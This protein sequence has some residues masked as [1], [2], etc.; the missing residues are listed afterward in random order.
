MG[1]R[2]IRSGQGFVLLTRT[3]GSSGVFADEAARDTYFATANGIIDLARMDANE[4]II[5]KLLDDGAGEI[6]YQQRASGVFVDVTSLVQGETGPAGAT[7]NSFFFES[8]AARDDF[9]NVVGNEQL[10]M[11]GL[12]V[13]V[14]EGTVSTNFFWSGEDNPSTYDEDLFRPAS[15][16][17]SPGSL[18]LGEGGLSIS[19]G[20]RA[21]NTTNAY[22]ITSIPL[23]TEFTA[24]GNTPPFQYDFGVSSVLSL[25]A[26]FDTALSDPQSMQFVVVDTSMTSGYAIRPA[27]IGDLRVQAFA[28]T[29]ETDPV[30]LDVTFPVTIGEIGT[31]KSIVLDNKT[32]LEADDNIL[33]KFSGI[34]LFGGLQTTGIFNG[35]T[36]PYLDVD[37][38]ILTPRDLVVLGDAQPIVVFEDLSTQSTGATRSADDWHPS[39]SVF[40]QSFD[41]TT[42]DDEP[43]G[44]YIRP[45]GLKMYLVGSENGLV[46]EY[47][48]GTSWDVSTAVFLQS[49]NPSITNI[50]GVFFRPNGLTMFLLDATTDEVSEYVLGT[51]W[52]ISTAA[53]V[54]AVDLATLGGGT[55]PHDM[56][57]KADGRTFYI[58]ELISQEVEQ[59]D[60]S[61]PW[62]ISTA[63]LTT[64]FDVGM[65]EFAVS[66]KLDGTLMFVIDG[67]GVIQEFNLTT[68][69]LVD[70]AELVNTTDLS[71][72]SVRGIFHKPDGAKFYVTEESGDTIRE[73]NVGLAITAP[74]NLRIPLNGDTVGVNFINEA[75][76]VAASIQYQD[77]T[78]TLALSAVEMS[79]TAGD[80]LALVAD[81]M[82]LD[83]TG[84]ISINSDIFIDAIGQT[85]LITSVGGTGTPSF[86]L[87]DA[88][89]NN[90]L[91][92]EYDQQINNVN[93]TG[94]VDT[95]IDTTGG[96]LFLHSATNVS[97]DAR[98]GDTTIEATGDIIL[99]TNVA[100]DTDG[101]VITLTSDGAS[102]T[103]SIEFDDSSNALGASIV[104]DET[105]DDLTIT[106]VLGD[107]QLISTS[108]DIEIL[109]GSGFVGV[110]TSDPFSSLHV[111]DDNSTGGS[112]VGFNIEQAGTGDAVQ[113][114]NL[115]GGEV[116]SIGIDN[117]ADDAFRLFA[118]TFLG[119]GGGAGNWTMLT[120]GEFGINKIPRANHCLDIDTNLNTVVALYDTKDV[121]LEQ[122][123][124]VNGN[125]TDMYFN[126]ADAGFNQSEFHIFNENDNTDTM[127]HF[128]M[129]FTD[130]GDTG[131]L[132]VRFN[133]FVAVGIGSNDEADTLLHLRSEGA[134]TV[135]IET[136]ETTGTNGAIVTTFVGDQDP[137]GI[138]TGSPGDIYRRSNGTSSEIF[139]H[140]GASADNTS[141][142]DIT[143][144][145]NVTTTDSLDNGLLLKAT[146][147]TSIAATEGPGSALIRTTSGNNI[148]QIVPEESGTGSYVLQ[149]SESTT[150][151]ALEYDDNSV[152]ANL[153]TNVKLT[154][155]TTSTLAVITSLPD[156]F[157]TMSLETTGTNGAETN[158]FVGD[159]DPNGAITG[160]GGDEYRRVSA[161]LSGSYESRE[162]T[163]GTE[164]FKRSVTPT[165]MDEINTAAEFEAL[166]SGGVIT[167]T[168]RR[169]IVLNVDVVTTT[170]FDIQGPDGDLIFKSENDS[171][172]IYVGTG[173]AFTLSGVGSQLEI[174]DVDCLAS[175]TATWFDVTGGT[176]GLSI[177]NVFL[178]S[179]TFVGGTYGTF[180]RTAGALQGPFLGVA[181]CIF[182]NKLGG[183]VFNDTTARFDFITVGQ[184]SGGTNTDTFITIATTVNNPS[185]FSINNVGGR[186]ATSD[187]FLKI[188]PALQV[189][190]TV[191]L[192]AIDLGEETLLFDTSGA[193]GTFT[194]VADAAVAATAVTSVTDSSGA[195]RF[196][197]TVGPTLFVN[198]EVVI[199][200]FTTNT[201]YNQTALI[202]AVGAGFFEV[203]YILFGSDETGSFLSNSVTLTDTATTLVDDDRLTLD[204]DDAT[205]YDG[206]AVVYNQQTNT[207]QVNGSFTATQTGTWSQAGLDQTDP[208]VLANANPGFVSSKY[209][210]TA[211]VNDN[212]TANGAITNNVFT[213]MV[214][215]TAGTALAV[216]STIERWKLIDELNGTFEYTGDEPFDGYITFDFTVVSSGG[217]VDFRFKWVRNSNAVVS[218]NFIDFVNSN[219]DE[220]FNQFDDFKTAG[221]Q[222]DDEI[223]ISG[224]ASNDGNYT[225]AV[226]NNG[227]LVLVGSDTLVNEAN[228]PLVT[229]T[230]LEMDLPDNV[231][232]LV[233]VGSDAQ[234]ITKTFPLRAEKGDQI[235]PQIT[236]N[237]GSS[238]ITTQY[239]TIYAT[240]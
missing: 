161:A 22:G 146:G 4:F 109:A 44:T 175:S 45:D 84:D 17:S 194:A 103:P 57:F 167:V 34:T 123:N 140:Q 72:T 121:T 224:S 176:I 239:A 179:V 117:S 158:T 178:R 104:F 180:R 142:T 237:S 55:N 220:I 28:G 63:T 206:G 50:L 148:I 19:S 42:Q 85:I 156:T 91:L 205:D 155:D 135:A 235:R 170:V 29:A 165:N 70:T 131:G 87:A 216:G 159:Q 227:R 73:F 225:L 234:S 144:E 185:V 49:F 171:D 166:A 41:T 203:D 231:E 7:G 14:N 217:S 172:Y 219:P 62:D 193:T 132:S 111:F 25:A 69:W 68:P 43:E 82:T 3:D 94:T 51:A 208:K 197:F 151:L 98:N 66:F 11:N 134:D 106:A 5:I 150:R 52:D 137:T 13:V 32:L 207:V 116:W 236:R 133:G 195:A 10:L 168:T 139:L 97:L 1:V 79:I 184:F 122:A 211:F 157:P 198:Q 141:W 182:I 78:Q 96:S 24:A 48:L 186:L 38:A 23:I 112:A 169:T 21:I 160:A 80:V 120:T 37:F 189:G 187:T 119:G 64:V 20:A 9:F 118:S 215:G 110:N 174:D 154:I 76:G 221:F 190:S 61:T 152:T 40:K 26:V 128:H 90:K 31:V 199:S 95:T 149:D 212:S 113:H 2:Y 191:V 183:F 162:A 81:E 238:G 30:I 102:G 214:F 210:A 130:A 114:F 188:D 202:T 53:F 127:R 101:R 108:S 15:V 115:T 196:N 39:A 59:Y 33:L 230:A 107:L 181:T 213:D 75:D 74:L 129:N 145:G 86:E 54:Q 12:P 233:N 136:L 138:V 100:V 124:S 201:D 126:R 173:T 46:Y 147:G 204:T 228:G 83:T 222:V 36:V 164:W 163:T 218:N 60:M 8:I 240:Q 35:Q 232:A 192:Q 67:A 18:F 56:Y 153:T 99:N 229:I 209:I 71:L 143:S 27:T 226:V 77:T 200:G 65:T 47:D 58:P 6:A 88:S 105:D 223:S 93:I 177:T 92:I 16:G 125:S 89:F